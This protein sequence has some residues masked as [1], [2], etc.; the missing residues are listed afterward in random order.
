MKKLLT[1]FRGVDGD[2]GTAAGA[3]ARRVPGK[4]Q[5]AVAR[6]RPEPVHRVCPRGGERG[7]HRLEG[8]GGGIAGDGVVE[9][10]S[11][12]FQ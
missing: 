8:R 1:L 4:H 11:V 3:E 9:N 12:P 7:L 5:T 10:D 2:D 6:V